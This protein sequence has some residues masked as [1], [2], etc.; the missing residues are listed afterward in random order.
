M[1]SVL[2]TRN[3]L[4]MSSV[5]YTRNALTMS[6]VLYTRNALTMSSVLYTRNALTMSSVL[7]TRNALTMSSVLT[8]STMHLSQI[9]SIL[10]PLAK[11]HRCLFQFLISTLP[12]PIRNIKHLKG[13]L[14]VGLFLKRWA[15]QAF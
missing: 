4:T 14:A 3:A 1:S 15:T 12:P 7:Y 9:T 6:S 8:I 2:Y 10:V 13:F 5:L 11:P